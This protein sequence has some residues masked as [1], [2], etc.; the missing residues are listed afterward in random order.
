[1]HQKR[2]VL[3]HPAGMKALHAIEE[4]SANPDNIQV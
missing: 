2:D 4:E 1:V 3:D